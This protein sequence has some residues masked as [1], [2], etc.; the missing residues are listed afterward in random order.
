MS[1]EMITQ[2]PTVT[3]ALLTDITMAVQGYVSPA[4]PGT[5]VQQTWGQVADLMLGQTILSY[6]GNPNGHVAGTIYQFCWDIT[7]T[8]LYICTTTGSTAT[9]V[10]TQVS[11]AA[12]GIISPALGGTGVASPT[13]NGV[14]IAE[15][16]SN[17]NFVTLAN[18][19]LL[20]GSTG[21][22]PVAANITAGTNISIVNTPGGI[23][24]AATGAGGFSWTHVTGTTQS[25]ASNNGYVADNAGLVTLTLP[26]VSAFGDEIEII[27]RGAGG[28][29]VAQGA[30]Q[31]IIFGNTQT[32]AGAGGSLASTNRRDSFYMVC[33]VANLEWTIADAPM[34]I[35]TV[36]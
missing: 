17:F 35:L 28:W 9:A 10:W 11:Q 3:Q 33:T 14:A 31:Q 18:G 7:D 26:S 22:D 36:V 25:M 29:L 15:G 20:I 19:Q 5:S 32:T 4:N 21:A 24:I 23:Q 2:L 6:A 34:G 30:G 27:G 12:G 8:I 1:N 16:A 13:A